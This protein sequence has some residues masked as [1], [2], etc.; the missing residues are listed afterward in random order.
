MQR[1][2]EDVVKPITLCRRSRMTAICAKATAGV[3]VKRT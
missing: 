2:L 3:D 1:A